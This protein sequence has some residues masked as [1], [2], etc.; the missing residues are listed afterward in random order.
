MK[1]IQLT[2][3]ITAPVDRVFAAAIDIP[4]TPK[5]FPQ[6]IRIEVL[7]PGPIAPGYRWRETRTAAGREVTVELTIT[8]LTDGRSFSVSCDVM[9]CRF[10]TRF[11]FSPSPTASNDSATHVELRTDVHPR[12]LLANL[13]S[14]FMIKPMAQGL[15][16]DLTALKRAVEQVPAHHPPRAGAPISR[17]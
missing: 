5:I 8:E 17:P 6:I 10:D 11:L 14:R 7:T 4:N 1:G 16:E 13:L 12:G 3:N 15:R 2:E 9:N